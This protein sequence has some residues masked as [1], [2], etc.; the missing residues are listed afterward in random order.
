[1][2]EKQTVGYIYG[3]KTNYMINCQLFVFYRVRGKSLKANGSSSFDISY[4]ET[5]I[6]SIYKIVSY[7]YTPLAYLPMTILSNKTMPGF[8]SPH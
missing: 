8:L 2:S 1:M 3:N 6:S 7:A 5:R 4:H